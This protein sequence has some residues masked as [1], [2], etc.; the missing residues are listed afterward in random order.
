MFKTSLVILEECRGASVL[1]KTSLVMLE[2]CLEASVLKTSLVMLEE[3]LEAPVLHICC[4]LFQKAFLSPFTFSA[5]VM[6]RAAE[7]VLNLC[8]LTLKK[9]KVRCNRMMGNCM[10]IVAKSCQGWQFHSP[11]PPPPFFLFSFFSFSYQG[12]WKRICP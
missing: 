8:L 6:A 9:G 12:S 5:L 7:S 4:I 2:E 3:C 10:L 11:P 1:N